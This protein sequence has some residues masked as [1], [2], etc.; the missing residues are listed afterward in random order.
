MALYVAK[1]PCLRQL[2][3]HFKDDL[4][5]LP[6]R[7]SKISPNLIST[8]WSFATACSCESGIDPVLKGS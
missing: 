4:K 1:K 3:P 6:E 8:P 2:I 5:E 7:M